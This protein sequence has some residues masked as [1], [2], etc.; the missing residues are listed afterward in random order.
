MIEKIL[1]KFNIEGDLLNVET[2]T[3]GNIN[4]TYVATFVNNDIVL[5]SFKSKRIISTC[6]L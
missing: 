4:N 6:V 5:A 3:A 2:N 1:E